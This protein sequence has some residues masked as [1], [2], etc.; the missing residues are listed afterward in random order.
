[1][2]KLFILS[3]ILSSLIFLIPSINAQRR[4]RPGSLKHTD[5]DVE[6]VY[7]QEPVTCTYI[8][9]GATFYG[10]LYYLSD[11]SSNKM[12]MG[13]ATLT[14]NNGK[15]K[16][17]FEATKYK[18][19]DALPPDQKWKYNPWR[20]E[21]LANDFIS[22]GKFI[23]YKRNGKIYIRLEDDEGGILWKDSEIENINSKA[24]GGIDNNILY[25]FELK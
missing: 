3:L 13:T 24:F 7:K 5:Q 25:A 15:Y 14:L 16:L 1:M 21:K 10:E 17:K 23:T 6:N 11:N 22:E 12:K 20:Y 2:K 19:R 9:N 4:S 18:T 8:K